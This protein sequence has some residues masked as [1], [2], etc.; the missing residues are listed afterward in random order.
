M[1]ETIRRNT[2]AHRA[3]IE[4]ARNIQ[5]YSLS[6]NFVPF[7]VEGPCFFRSQSGLTPVELLKAEAA[8]GAQLRNNGDGTYTLKVHSNSWYKFTN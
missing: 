4:N 6:E 8:D 5:A 2:K 1:T 3:I 7:D